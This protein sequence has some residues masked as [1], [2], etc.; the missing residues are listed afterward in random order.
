[1]EIAPAVEVIVVDSSAVRA[2]VPALA[3]VLMDAVRGGA[4]VS[5]MADLAREDAIRFWE[6]VAIEVEAGRRLRPVARRP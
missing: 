6:G 2:I 3:D 5:F 1:M 4:S